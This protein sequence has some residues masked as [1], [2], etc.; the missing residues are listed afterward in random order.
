VKKGT[1]GSAS[2]HVDAPPETV[3]DVVSDVRR[4]GEWSPECRECAWL[5]GASGPVVGA[6]FKGTNRKGVV[7]WSTKPKVVAATRGQTFSF[8]TDIT[9][10]SYQFD[11]E[12]GGTKVTES[13][14]MT[15]D[16][17]VLLDLGQR[18]FLR[19]KDRR[20]DLEAGMGVTLAR[21]KQAVERDVPST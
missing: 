9:R 19:I 5:D 4:M 16:E 13:F 14:E 8:A 21:I 3:Y 18:Y 15:A 12:S 1:T 7:R 6:R 10:W 11:P 17:P 20:A 2:I